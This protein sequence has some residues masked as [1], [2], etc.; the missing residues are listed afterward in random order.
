MN[1][2]SF[3]QSILAAGAAAPFVRFGSLMQMVRRTPAGIVYL[4]IENLDLSQ[5]GNRVPEIVFESLDRYSYAADVPYSDGA[6][7]AIWQLA[8]LVRFGG[9]VEKRTETPL[10]GGGV[11]ADYKYKA[12]SIVVAAQEPVGRLMARDDLFGR[13]SLVSFAVKRRDFPWESEA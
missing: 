13:S 10:P 2:R 4:T 3:I 8:P 1:R 9:I 6:A 5:F 12:A 11:I 7:D